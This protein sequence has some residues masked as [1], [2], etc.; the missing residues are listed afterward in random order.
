VWGRSGISVHTPS[1]TPS[2]SA[3]SVSVSLSRSPQNFEGLVET[4][5]DPSPTRVLLAADM[6]RTAPLVLAGC[7][8]LVHVDGGLVGHSDEKVANRDIS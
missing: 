1:A 2:L 7:Q 8:S 4:C 3:H 6:Q 5:Q